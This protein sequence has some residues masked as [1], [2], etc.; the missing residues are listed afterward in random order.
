VSL[1]FYLVSDLTADQRRLTPEK[2]ALVSSR[3]VDLG[4]I[5]LAE[6]GPLSVES[7]RQVGDSLNGA[8]LRPLHQV[9]RFME[10]VVLNRTD[11]DIFTTPLTEAQCFAFDSFLASRYVRR[12][13]HRVI[14]IAEAGDMIRIAPLRFAPPL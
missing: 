10:E 3:A 12:R 13:V 5:P 1:Q 11:V 9:F 7:L 14:R 2:A 6:K 4:T 8:A